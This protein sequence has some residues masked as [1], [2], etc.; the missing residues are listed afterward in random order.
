MQPVVTAQEM[1]AFDD[2]A[3]ATT[4]HGVLVDRAGRAVAHEV[5]TLL[6]DVRGRRIVVI[7]GK[8]SNGAD[9]R[10]AARAL[11]SHGA[12]VSVVA[13]T[14]ADHDLDG[15]DL[16]IDAAF[17]TGCSRDY[18]APSAPADALVVA[19]DLPSGLDATT[20]ELRG[21]PLPADVTVT[22]AAIKAG[23]LLGSGPAVAGRV[24]VADIGIPTE[25]SS[26]EMVGAEDLAALPER[27]SARNKWTSAVC[28]VA[29]SPGM[30]GAAVLASLGALR[31][32]AGMVRLVHPADEHS[33][34]VTWPIEVVRF[35]VDTA[36]LVETVRREEA[37]AGAMVL[38][39]G[40]GRRED[41]RQAVR[42]LV[43]TRTVPVVLDADALAC[44]GDLAALRALVDAAASPVVLTPHDGEL[45]ALLGR[46]LVAFERMDTLRQTAELSGATVLSKGPTTVVVGTGR[47][48]PQAR[49]IVAGSPAL[50]TAGTGDV[51]SGV[52]GALLA[53][54]ASPFD[55]ASLG[56]VLH[57]LAGRRAPGTLIA[58]ELPGLVGEVLREVLD[59]C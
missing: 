22:M 44:V 31:A 10:V 17:G 5:R 26:L 37:R 23:L 4:A 47:A 42:E 30:E 40:L 21:S 34:G 32:G 38:G 1:A 54:G 19:V 29:G 51:L 28:V 49:M 6:G 57:G 39:P 3:L 7:A 8:G 9:G 35:A 25:G 20:G 24:V 50:A 13:P 43:A 12:I 48:N 2:A 15:A 52:I 46:P 16:I 33:S 53:A 27:S 45:A 14:C 36:D 18:I 59:G 56:A 55:A 58:S 11:A 41:T